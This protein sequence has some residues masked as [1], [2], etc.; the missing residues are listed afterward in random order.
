MGHT[1]GGNVEI[2]PCHRMGGNQVMNLSKV[3]FC[4][5]FVLLLVGFVC[6]RSIVIQTKENAVFVCVCVYVV[7]PHQ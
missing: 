7:V 1:N 6:L 2:G 4:L 5:L 3:L